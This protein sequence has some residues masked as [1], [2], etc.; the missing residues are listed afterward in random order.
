MVSNQL[1]IWLLVVAGALNSSN[2]SLGGGPALGQD[3]ARPLV[4]MSFGPT[5]VEQ[6]RLNRRGGKPMHE[7]TRVAL[8][9]DQ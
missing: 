4:R 3:H 1:A 6:R 9:T 7:E 5:T 8:L 2:G